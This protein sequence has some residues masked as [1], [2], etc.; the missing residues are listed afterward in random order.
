MSIIA[1]KKIK[2]ISKEEV[3]SNVEKAMNLAKWKRYVKGKKVFIKTNLLIK[4]VI[5]GLCTSPW[6]IEGII[7]VLK[8]DNREIWRKERRTQNT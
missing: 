1:H 7:K 6:V 2:R 3:I 4:R 8:K 5:P